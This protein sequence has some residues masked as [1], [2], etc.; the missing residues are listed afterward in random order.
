MP[1]EERKKKVQNLLRNGDTEIS[2]LGWAAETI[3]V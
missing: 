3:L 1:K 2:N